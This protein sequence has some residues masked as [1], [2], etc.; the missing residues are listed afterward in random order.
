MIYR[1]KSAWVQG[2]YGMAVYGLS[3]EDLSASAERCV[4]GT[5]RAKGSVSG[6]DEDEGKGK[7]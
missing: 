3:K 7:E 2:K 6:E 4:L 5:C 1:M